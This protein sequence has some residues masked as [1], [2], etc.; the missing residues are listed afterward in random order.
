[1]GDDPPDGG[2]QQRGVGWV[3]DHDL[4]FEHDPVGVVEDLGLVAE[5]DRGA[6]AALAERPDVRV[7]QADQPAGP[8]RHPAGKAGVEVDPEGLDEHR[9]VQQSVHHR[10]SS[11]A[12]IASHSDRWRWWSAASTLQPVVVQG[13][14]RIL[15]H[16]AI[17]ATQPTAQTSSSA[18]LSKA[19]S[20]QVTSFPD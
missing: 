20:I 4:M 17:Q 8:V 12:R 14:K 7:V 15:R 19:S 11:A 6:D 9:V 1:V 16:S 10:A 18:T 13:I 2:G 3:A 5:L